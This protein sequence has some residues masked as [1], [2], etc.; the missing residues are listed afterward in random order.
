MARSRNRNKSISVSVVTMATSG[1]ATISEVEISVSEISNPNHRLLQ[2]IFRTVKC[3]MLVVLDVS[4]V[5]MATSPITTDVRKFLTYVMGTM[6]RLENVLA[7]SQESSLKTGSVPIKTV[8]KLCTAN[9]LTVWLG[10]R[11]MMMGFVSTMTHCAWR[12]STPDVNNARVDT[13]STSRA[14]A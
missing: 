8:R 13:T 10:S 12:V 7:A 4:F 3:P 9:A 1:S 6:C 11:R 5:C 14:S 2:A